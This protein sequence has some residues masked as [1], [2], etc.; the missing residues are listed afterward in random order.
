MGASTHASDRKYT[1]VSFIHYS[2]FVYFDND[3]GSRP[4]LDTGSRYLLIRTESSQR[5]DV[6]QEGIAINKHYKI[7]STGKSLYY[8]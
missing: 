2:I 4:Q 6:L 8:F 3:D 5:Q 7:I 1:S